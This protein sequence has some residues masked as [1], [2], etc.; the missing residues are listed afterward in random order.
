MTYDTHYQNEQGLSPAFRGHL[1][2]VVDLVMSKMQGRHVVEIGCGKGGF[3][4]M[5][6]G[7]GLDIR[8]YDPAYEGDVIY[9]LLRHRSGKDVLGVVDINPAKQG[10]HLAS[11]GLQVDSPEIALARIPPGTPIL[12]MN[13]IYLDEV[14]GMSGRP[15]DCLALS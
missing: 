6:A 14:R 15:A 9:A 4:N 10:Y 5:L 2:S 7:R 1:A 13:H 11:T 12:V 8:G 3:P